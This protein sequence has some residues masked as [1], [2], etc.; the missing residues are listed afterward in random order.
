MTTEEQTRIDEANI[1]AAIRDMYDAFIADDRERFD[2]HLHS[3][4]TTWE[5]A[6]PTM[7]TRA[8]L[9]AYRDRRGANGARPVVHEMQVDPRRVDV[10]GDTAIFAYV[11]RIVAADEKYVGVARITDVLRRGDDQW[12]IVHHH[13]QDRDI[14]EAQDRD[15]LSRHE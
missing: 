7:Y 1:I 14:D 3:D 8:E 2:S 15:T 9:D 4:T 12:R 10:W 5:S 11:L 6:L 13:A